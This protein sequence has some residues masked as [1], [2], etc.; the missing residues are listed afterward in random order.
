MLDFF[1]VSG[2]VKKYNFGEIWFLDIETLL[3]YLSPVG[4]KRTRAIDLSIVD[5]NAAGDAVS[6]MVEQ[7][8][9]SISLLLYAWLSMY[10]D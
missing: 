7:P 10:L 8:P 4:T 3:V 1:Q 6:I 5:L 2:W 9:N